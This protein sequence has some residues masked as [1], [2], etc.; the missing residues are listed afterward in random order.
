MFDNKDGKR[1]LCVST[2]FPPGPGGIGTHAYQLMRE[3]SRLGWN[4]RVATSQDHATAAEVKEFNT[5]APFAVTTFRRLPGS[6]VRALERAA[7]LATILRSWKP[8]LIIASGDR[9]VWLTAS[10]MRFWPTRWIAVGH[11]SEFGLT[12]KWEQKLIKS[13]FERADAAVCVSNFTQA[14][15]TA[16]CIRPQRTFVIPN[17]AD[18][19]VFRL[20]PDSEVRDFRAEMNFKTDFLLL[21]VGNVTERKGQE[22]VIRALPEVMRTFPNTHYLICG[23]PTLKNKLRALA[24]EL[25]ITGHV[26]FLGRVDQAKLVRLTNACD[27]FVMTSRRTESGDC[28]GYGI[29]AVEAALCGKPAIV[30]SGSGLAEAIVDGE[31]GICVPPDDPSQTARS[32]LDLLQSYEA[33]RAMGAAARERAIRELTWEKRALEYDRVLRQVT[34]RRESERPVRKESARA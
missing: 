29:A 24:V 9:A 8:D 32:I 21:T 1:L 31:T 30:S 10:L 19:S 6:P 7:T 17:G 33:R 16:A 3:L 26:H 12:A 28:E 27:I 23:L 25:E 13:G 4:V 5:K 14:Q 2:E 11:G 20:L 34:G 15:M 18:A 22:T